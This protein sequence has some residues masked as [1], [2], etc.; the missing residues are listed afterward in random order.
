MEKIYV[1]N[2]KAVSKDKVERYCK[3]TGRIKRI[4]F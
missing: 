3:R 4:F 2:D 1:K